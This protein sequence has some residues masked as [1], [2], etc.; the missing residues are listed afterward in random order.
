[1]YEK[2]NEKV[3]KDSK[4]IEREYIEYGVSLT[5]LVIWLSEEEIIDPSNCLVIL[6]DILETFPINDIEILFEIF[7]NKFLKSQPLV[8]KFN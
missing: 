8:S 5:N 4:E 6:D 2:L 3:Q 7:V 1:M